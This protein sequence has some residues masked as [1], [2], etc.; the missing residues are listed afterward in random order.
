MNRSGILLV[1][2]SE[3]FTS[4]DAVSVVRRIFGLRRVGHAGTL[5]PMATGLL[6]VCLGRATRAVEFLMEGSKEY[7]A[8]FKLGISTTTQ[9]TT[10]EITAR[11]EKSVTRD[12][13]LS[14]LKELT[15][16]IYQLPPMYSALKR[17]GVPLY[18]LARQGIEVERETRRITI[19]RIDLLEYDE[20]ARRGRIR[21]ACSKGTYIRTLCADLGGMLGTG[22]VMSALRRTQSGEY[23]VK[24]A[25]TLDEI[26]EIVESAGSDGL[27]KPVDSVF[28]RYP[29]LHV[30]AG[31]ERLIK[32]GCVVSFTAPDGEYRVYSDSG[33][34][35]GIST[36][37]ADTLRV[38]KS[39]FET[40]AG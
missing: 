21:V 20:S 13:L 15:G 19:E 10:G 24:D 6:V 23:S 8:G 2:K 29:E 11:S 18:R 4:Q 5:D 35:L 38:I 7:E 40:D 34:F 31:G 28:E 1:D 17:G 9:D 12:E 30:D 39:F 27:L 22:G 33:K 37:H 3:D 16:E 32:N 25:H 14:A 36:V 26:A